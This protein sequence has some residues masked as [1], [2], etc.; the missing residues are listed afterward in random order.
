[1]C[2]EAGIPLT[3]VSESVAADS[4]GKH[5]RVFEMLA[6]DLRRL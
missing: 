3:L 5:L 2:E 1:M 4:E 6:V